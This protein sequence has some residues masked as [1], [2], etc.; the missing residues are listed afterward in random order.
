[1]ANLQH[2][3]D[4]YLQ[5]ESVI[6]LIL[7]TIRDSAASTP[8]VAENGFY[9]KPL[10][11]KQPTQLIRIGIEIGNTMYPEISAGK[12]RYSVRFMRVDGAEMIPSQVKEDVEFML[13]RCTL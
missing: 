2:W 7:K 5:L 1:M 11:S 8:A 6:D 12:H 4:P 10:D 13:S 9:Q 3:A